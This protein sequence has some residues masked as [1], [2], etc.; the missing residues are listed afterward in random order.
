[1]GGCPRLWGH[2]TSGCGAW[3]QEPSQAHGAPDSRTAGSHV[4]V[5]LAPKSVVAVMAALENCEK[6]PTV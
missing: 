6:D 3:S 5:V 1:M 2:R 4:G